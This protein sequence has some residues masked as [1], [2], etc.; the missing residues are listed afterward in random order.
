MRRLIILT[1]VGLAAVAARPV[2]AQSLHDDINLLKAT[3]AAVQAL[4][5]RGADIHAR[6][7]YG[8]TPLRRAARF[9]RIPAVTALLLDRGADATL[10]TEAG[11]LPVELAAKNKVLTG[12]DVYWRLNEARF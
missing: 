4:L 6:D 12:T 2:T 7:K 5:D 9:N 8:A 11:A 1:L 10:R 3:P